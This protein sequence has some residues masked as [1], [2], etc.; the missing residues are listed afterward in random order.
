[1][2]IALENIL[3]ARILHYKIYCTYI[4]LENI[5]DV[6]CKYIRRNI[7]IALILHYKIYGT[8]IALENIWYVHST[9]KYMVH[10]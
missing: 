1:M 9:R 10:T 8:Y 5:F 2:F 7:L 4:A 6:H 3:I